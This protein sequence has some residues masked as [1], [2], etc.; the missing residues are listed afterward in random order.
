[1]RNDRVQLAGRQGLPFDLECVGIGLAVRRQRVGE[2]GRFHARQTSG[3]A[4]NFLEEGKSGTG[5]L[6]L[7][8]AG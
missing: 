8:V 1:V 2:R 7:L 5:I 3:A 6:V 4:E